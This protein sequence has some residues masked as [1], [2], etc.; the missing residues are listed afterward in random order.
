MA[1]KDTNAVDT[2]KT[3]RRGRLQ[4]S[5]GVAPSEVIRPFPGLK[6]L[7]IDE[8]HKPFFESVILRGT[9]LAS[10]YYDQAAGTKTRLKALYGMTDADLTLN[11]VSGEIPKGYYAVPCIGLAGLKPVILTYDVSAGAIATAAYDEAAETAK[12]PFTFVPNNV[13][14]GQLAKP[15]GVA[16]MDAYRPFSR[17]ENEGVSF[18]CKQYIEYPIMA[19]ENGFDNSGIIVGDY[20]KSDSLGRPVKWNQGE[21]EWLRIG[22]VIAREDTGAN[23]AASGFSAVADYDYGFLNYMMLP[24]GESLAEAMLK[25]AYGTPF[26]VKGNLNNLMAANGAVKGVIR[27]N[28]LN[29]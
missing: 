29:L 15:I 10:F 25:E 21:P 1:Y 12:H 7:W 3:Y 2:T 18:F 26:G 5:E 6:T 14:D 27:V 9:I 17:G 4:V 20:I 8:T 13:L 19:V 28:L 24:V 11:G 22:Q 23:G 16:S